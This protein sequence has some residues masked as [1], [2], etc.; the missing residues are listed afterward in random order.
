MLRT[1][2]SFVAASAFDSVARDPSLRAWYL[3]AAHEAL[4]RL[5]ASVDRNPF[6]PSYGCCDRQYWHYRTAAFASE[7]YQ[8]AALPL[9]QAFAVRRPGSI[10]HGESRLAEAA[11]AAMRFSCR[12]AH[13]DGSADDYYPFERALGAVVF[14]LVAHVQA[15][16]LLALDDDALK[17]FF[18]H[19]AEWIAAHD[20][21]GRLTNHHALAALALWRTAELVDSQRLRQAAQQRID[22]VLAWQ[23]SEGWFD[24]YGGADPGY[25]TVTI[26]CLAK[27]RRE[28]VRPDLAEPLRRA[29]SFAAAFPTVDGGY[30]GVYGSR[31]TR[32]FYPSGLELLAAE[33]SQAAD[34]ADGFLHSLVAGSAACFDDDR[35][36]VHRLGSLFDAYDHWSPVRPAATSA[37]NEA[38]TTT[39]STIR[40]FPHAGLNVVDRLSSD[41]GTAKLILSLARGGT[42]HFAR[43]SGHSAESK[44][45]QSV[46]DAGLVVEFDDGRVAVSQLHEAQP[47]SPADR[48]STVVSSSE[49]LPE[50]EVVRSPAYK[51]FER[52]TPLK[53]AML[54]VGM[55][56][57]GRYARN[58]V[59]KLLQRRVIA[60][61]G[62]APLRIRR[63]IAWRGTTSCEP[64]VVV[65]ELELTAAG[66]VRR[67]AFATDLQA[68]Y[69]AAAEVFAPDLLQPW[70]DLSAYVDTLNRERRVTIVREF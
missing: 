30:G 57:F 37:A 44:S 47:A 21:S 65:D 50:W 35:M 7:M 19:R 34:L 69:T 58:A 27:L 68:A 16:R 26:D 22:R 56:T 59:R 62:V 20:E 52:A 53:Q 2:T 36:Y 25:Q 15:Y 9:A 6:S 48:P 49:M 32:H 28:A 61:G 23:S 39:T 42:F 46:V 60:G 33:M 54:H 17:K 51:R 64:L 43:Q 31:G 5:L 55:A 38:S 12:A 10:W 13:A 24:E 18:A 63:R 45:T 66:R 14:S 41:G 70:H 4:P 1:E 29:V 3:R 8:E 40:S 67:L 11:V